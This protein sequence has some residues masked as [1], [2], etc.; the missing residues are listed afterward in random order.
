MKL[1]QL[2]QLN[3][4]I[5]QINFQ[6][7]Y[8][9]DE[10][11]GGPGLGTL[12]AGAGAA[13]LVGGGLYARGRA[14]TPYG[15]LPQ[16]QGRGVFST[17]KQGAG[18]LMGDAGSAYKG[19]AKGAARAGAYAGGVGAALKD[20]VGTYNAHR[21]NMGAGVGRALAGAGRAVLDRLK[22]LRYSAHHSNLVQLNAR[23][24]EVINFEMD[25]DERKL[26]LN[27]WLSHGGAGMLGAG[28]VLGHV[29]IKEKGG[30]RKV[31]KAGL[32]G[33]KKLLRMGK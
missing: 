17:M 24:D 11:E 2:V 30:Y 10:P 19:A 31:G 29:R 16:G 1:H 28:G 14:A 25:E 5:D 22:N 7:M 12:A 6:N 27:D 15:P 9:E 23:L 8:D 13:G 3:A 21:T 20:T 33:L 18:A 32:D 26:R 4:K